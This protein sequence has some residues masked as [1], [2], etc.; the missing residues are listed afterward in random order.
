MPVSRRTAIQMATLTAVLAVPA[1]ASAGTL[2]VGGGVFAFSAGPA[3]PGTRISFHGNYNSLAEIFNTEVT[4]VGVP[5]TVVGCEDD[6]S[7]AD[8]G[9]CTNVGR[10]NAY[11]LT[12]SGGND[13]IRFTHDD[14]PGQPVPT[15]QLAAGAG[16][17]VAYF[18]GARATVDGG[19]GDDVLSPDYAYGSY[20]SP[21]TAGD[22]VAGGPGTDRLDAGDRLPCAAG[23]TWVATLDDRADDGCQGE[24]DN[25]RADL[26]QVVGTNGRDRIVGTDGPNVLEGAG[27]GDTLI[28]AGGD[29]VLRADSTSQGSTR[30]EDDTTLDGGDGNDELV[31]G[32]GDDRLIGGAGRDSANGGSGNDT[33]DLLDGVDDDRAECG[34]GADRVQA[35]AGDVVASDC[36]RVVWAPK[37]SSSTLRYRAKGVNVKLACPKT[38]RTTCSGKLRLTTTAGRTLAAKLYQAKRGRS[39]TVRLRLKR[40]P[41]RKAT[42]IVAPKGTKPTAG[43]AVT[44][45]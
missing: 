38:S 29:D 22:V 2:T 28:G 32:Q 10:P 11:T 39:T 3:D 13:D 35:D 19:E 36:E 30:V 14:L 21:V 24:A 12:A 8:G 15:L 42:L 4:H 41:A 43:R 31:G 5:V 25:Y 17:D 18:S 20:A 37:A 26:E 23:D 9:L 16:N 6:A 45:R 7:A 33:I 1:V 34:D 44:V 40:K 27:G